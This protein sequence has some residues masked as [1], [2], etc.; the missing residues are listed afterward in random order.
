MY[1]FE[2]LSIQC[3]DAMNFDDFIHGIEITEHDLNRFRKTSWS[4]AIFD[5]IVN[6]LHQMPLTQRPLHTTNCK[7]LRL[8]LKLKNTWCSQD[9]DSLLFY[10]FMK[11]LVSKVASAIQQHNYHR[12]TLP[13]VLVN[14]WRNQVVLQKRCQLL[15]LKICKAVQLKA[16]PTANE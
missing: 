5:L 15:A 3:K 16:L 10:L 1:I 14:D 7:Q 2:F 11:Y 9:E 12:F 8:Y 4:K 13:R 6:K